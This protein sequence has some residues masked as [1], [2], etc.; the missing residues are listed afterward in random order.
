[1]RAEGLWLHV[2]RRVRAYRDENRIDFIGV[3][4]L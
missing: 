3:G 1:M 2:S 4:N